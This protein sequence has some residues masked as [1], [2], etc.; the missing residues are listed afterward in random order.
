M[1]IELASYNLTVC[2]HAH[3]ITL[4]PANNTQSDVLPNAL[5][6]SLF[7]SMPSKNREKRDRLF[8]DK[9]INCRLRDIA[10]LRLFRGSDQLP[11]Q[12][13]C[14][15]VQ[16]QTEGIIR[17]MQVGVYLG[18]MDRNDTAIGL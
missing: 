18:N 2:G 9:W 14:A 5:K 3:I 15:E 11:F 8:G 7:P 12:G 4:T 1:V 17:S 13:G 10:R 16:D 6:N